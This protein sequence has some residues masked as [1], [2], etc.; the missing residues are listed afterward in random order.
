MGCRGFVWRRARLAV[1]VLC[2]NIL[3]NGGDGFAAQPQFQP[4]PDIPAQVKALFD[5]PLRFTRAILPAL[6]NDPDPLGV[7]RCYDYSDFRV[8]ELDNGQHGDDAISVTRYDSVSRRPACGIQND[9][10]EIVLSGGQGGYFIGAKAR[11]VYVMSTLGEDVTPFTIYDAQTGNA[12]YGDAGGSPFGVS[13]SGGV[14]TLSYSHGAEGPCSI[15][16][17]QG[18]WQRFAGAAALPRAIAKRPAPV[19]ECK[20]S[21][22]EQQHTDYKDPSVIY[23]DVTITVTITG[24]TKVLSRGALSCFPES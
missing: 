23:W 11:F 7:V 22:D 20:Q 19:S 16:L 4:D 14:L 24:K 9:P 18:C 8:K 12:I 15:I 5:A 17:G 1:F 2:V 21:Y 13:I 6:P 10:G 3:L